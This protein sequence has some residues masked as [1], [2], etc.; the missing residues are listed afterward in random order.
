MLYVCYRLLTGFYIVIATLTFLGREKLLSNVF[1][2][3]FFILIYLVSILF[4]LLA[5]YWVSKDAK[6][7]G[8][9]ADIW[10]ILVFLGTLFFLPAYLIVRNTNTKSDDDICSGNLSFLSLQ[11]LLN[12]YNS[13]MKTLSIIGIIWFSLL[14]I[15]ILFSWADPYPDYDIL[16]SWGLLGLLYA[17][18]FSIIMLV[19]S[20]KKR[21]LSNKNIATALKDLGELKTNGIITEEEFRQQKEYI[22]RG[23]Y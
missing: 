20:L 15:V 11:L 7:K 10:T 3:Y 13:N 19:I 16:V 23:N 21:K 9:N 1:L 18:P 5:A 8:L 6:G 22:L 12:K 4:A 17:I 14:F 2:F